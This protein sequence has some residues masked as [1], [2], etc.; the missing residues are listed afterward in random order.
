MSAVD[1]QHGNGNEWGD[2]WNQWSPDDWSCDD[3]QLNSEWIGSLDD[4]PVTGLGPMTTGDI[5]LRTP[6]IL[7]RARMEPR[8]QVLMSLRTPPRMN[9][10]TECVPCDCR[11]IGSEYAQSFEDFPGSLD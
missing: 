2:E 7:S 4:W 9:H 5:G 11:T 10:H 3:S 1:N 8:A 6:L